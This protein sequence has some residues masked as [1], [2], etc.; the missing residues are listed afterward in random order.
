MLESN[1]IQI[2]KSGVK[3]E[4]GKAISRYNAEKHLILRETPTEYEQ[5]D[6]A[7]IFDEFCRDLQ[8]LGRTQELLVEI[9]A[10]N[11]IKL[12]RIGKAEGEVIKEALSPSSEVDFGFGRKKYIADID[13]QAL[14]K[15][16]LCS[17]YQTATENRIYRALAFLK[18]LKTYEQS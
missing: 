10:N 15:F 17:R 11:T 13:M 4:E 7:V 12:A 16:C 5:S 14:E 3:T 1:K 9:I 18:Q 2:N 8:P 6:V